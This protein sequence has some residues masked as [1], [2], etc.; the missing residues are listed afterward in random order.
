MRMRS[1]KML[2][3]RESRVNRFFLVFSILIISGCATF[4]VAKPVYPESG[5]P[6]KFVVV[7]SL[8]PVISWDQKF[9]GAVDFIL[10]EGPY[11]EDD[12]VCC[13]KQS[14]PGNVLYVEKDINDTKHKVKIELEPNRGYFWA[15][16][17]IGA[18]EKEEDWSSY[19]YFA[20]YGVAWTYY[21]GELFKFRT[22]SR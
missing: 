11:T 12:H 18:A 21:R 15:I 16:R 4:D 7:D 22:P 1:I 14:T 9:D 8:Q 6:H 3:L 20:F 19:N 10:F 13:G 2:V 17:K 5:W